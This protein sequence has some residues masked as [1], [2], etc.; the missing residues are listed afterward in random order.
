MVSHLKVYFNIVSLTIHLI[1]SVPSE[2]V[3]V[4]IEGSGISIAGEMY[5]LTCNVSVIS[6]LMNS[7]SAVWTDGTISIT[8][9]SNITVLTTVGNSYSISVLI[10]NPLRT[11]HGYDYTCCGAIDSPALNSPQTIFMQGTVTVR[12]RSA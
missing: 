6:G 7:P 10:F 5:T 8:N 9:E 12:S 2:A 1:F 11:S 3:Q 4:R